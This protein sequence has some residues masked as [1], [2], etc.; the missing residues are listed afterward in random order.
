MLGINQTSKTLE[1]RMDNLCIVRARVCVQCYERVC[2]RGPSRVEKDLTLAGLAY[3]HI[4]N[5]YEY[6]GGAR[7]YQQFHISYFIYR[8]SFSVH[9]WQIFSRIHFIF[10]LSQM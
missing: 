5:T 1:L 7:K 2:V 10:V 4:K 8:T 6:M 9:P 3:L